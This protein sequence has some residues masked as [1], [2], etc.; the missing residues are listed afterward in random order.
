MREREEILEI[1]GMG[2]KEKAL[3]QEAT[4]ELSMM[5]PGSNVGTYRR[6][7]KGGDQVIVNVAWS[8]PRESKKDT[9][10]GENLPVHKAESFRS[11]RSMM[12][13]RCLASPRCVANPVGL[14][15]KRLESLNQSSRG[16]AQLD[17]VAP[18]KDQVEECV[19]KS[20]TT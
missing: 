5:K 13:S 19:L 4:R 15:S 10:M 18:R 16:L 17:T 1:A 7:S 11:A 12:E 9:E 3:V 14:T 2:S 8:D 20:P 6:G